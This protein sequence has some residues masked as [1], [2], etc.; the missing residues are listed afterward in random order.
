[1]A[2]AKVGASQGLKGVFTKEIE[3]ALLDGRIDVAV[4][5]MKDLPTELDRR[6][7]IAAV[8]ERADPRD[9]MAG[10]RLDDLSQGAVVGTSSLRR[11]APMRKS[12]AAGCACGP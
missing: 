9:A 8:P 10:G 11:S 5:S 3:E 12:K 7:A 6:L 1:V 2:L 4:H